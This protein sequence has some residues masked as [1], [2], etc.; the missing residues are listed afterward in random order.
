MT[1]INGTSGKP[2]NVDDSR[3]T[4]EMLSR[5]KVLYYQMVV[6][7]ATEADVSDKWAC[8]ASNAAG[9]KFSYFKVEYFSKSFVSQLLQNVPKND[10][11]LL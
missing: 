4:V 10:V 6:R 9:Q 2:I 1:F 7:D 3:I 5:G 11:L 8:R